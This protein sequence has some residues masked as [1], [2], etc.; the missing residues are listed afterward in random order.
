M[1]SAYCDLATKWISDPGSL[2]LINF[3]SGEVSSTSP[4]EL[5]RMRS[6]FAVPIVRKYEFEDVLP[7]GESLEPGDWF[8]FWNMRE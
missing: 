8:A 7:I 6:F 1:R 5:K 2:S 4:A 3:R